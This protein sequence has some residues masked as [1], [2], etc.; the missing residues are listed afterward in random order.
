MPSA[1]LAPVVGDNISS[2]T[3][4]QTLLKAHHVHVR[5]SKI[6]MTGKVYKV[7]TSLL[8]S[9]IKQLNMALITKQ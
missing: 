5:N 3:N 9:R 2:I 8:V 7:Q 1:N 6:I 4:D